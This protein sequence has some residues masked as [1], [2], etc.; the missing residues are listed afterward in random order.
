MCEQYSIWIVKKKA[1]IYKLLNLNVVRHFGEKHEFG[2]K[3]I[4]LHILK[5][6]LSCLSLIEVPLVKVS[7]SN[8]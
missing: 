7:N 1:H 3:P 2:R 5:I 4:T 6:F 8:I